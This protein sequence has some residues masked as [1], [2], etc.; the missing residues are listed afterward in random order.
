MQFTHIQISPHAIDRA[1]RGGVPEQG[2]LLAAVYG[3]ARYYKGNRVGRT[4][5]GRILKRLVQRGELAPAVAERLEGTTVLTKDLQFFR[6]VVT[7]LPKRPLLGAQRFWLA[8]QRYLRNRPGNRV[9]SRS[10]KVA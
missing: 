3:E 2:I 6:L 4:L 1:H 7:T 10:A 5:T 8:N 9:R